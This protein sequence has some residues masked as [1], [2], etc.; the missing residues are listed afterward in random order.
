MAHYSRNVAHE[1]RATDEVYSLIQGYPNGVTLNQLMSDNPD[2]LKDVRSVLA[3]IDLLTE[4]G[5]VRREVTP[6]KQDWRDGITVTQI[7]ADL[8]LKGSR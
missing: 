3:A 7:P 1:S 2:R 5:K 6:G 4:E 8:K